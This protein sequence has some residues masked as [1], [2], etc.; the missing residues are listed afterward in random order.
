MR[1]K[2]LL[3]LCFFSLCMFTFGQ[4]FAGGLENLPTS[5][6]IILGAAEQAPYPLGEFWTLQ[7][8]DE[9]GER[10]SFSEDGFFAE[11]DGDLRLES[12]FAEHEIFNLPPGHYYFRLCTGDEFDRQHKPVYCTG[13]WV[14]VEP[15]AEID[16]RDC[17]WQLRDA[18]ER[19]K[20]GNVNSAMGSAM[21]KLIADDDSEVTV[22]LW[23][24]EQWIQSAEIGDDGMFWFEEVESSGG[25]ENQ[26]SFLLEGLYFNSIEVKVP[27]MFWIQ[28]VI[29]IDE[30]ATGNESGVSWQNAMKHPKDA[31]QNWSDYYFKP[32]LRIADGIYIMNLSS[33]FLQDGIQIYGGFDGGEPY[34]WQRDPDQNVVVFTGDLQSDD[35]QTNG[36]TEF[37]GGIR[38]TNA[39]ILFAISS[40][41]RRTILDGF[42]VTGYHNSGGAV[43][44]DQ[45]CEAVLRNIRF[46]GNQGRVGGALNTIPGCRPRIES[47][48]FQGNEA[49]FGGAIFLGDERQ[50]TKYSR[51]TSLRI[52]DC[53]F[54]GNEATEE[55]GG[56]IFFE[57]AAADSNSSIEFFTNITNC[58]F[59][60][61]ESQGNG[62][63]IAFSSSEEGGIRASLVNCMFSGNVSTAGAVLSSSLYHQDGLIDIEIINCSMNHNRANYGETIYNDVGIHTA[64]PTRGSTISIKNSILWSGKVTIPPYGEFYNQGQT[65][66]LNFE[67]NIIYGGVQNTAM[68]VNKYGATHVDQGGNLGH[69]PKFID[70]DGPDGVHGTLDDNLRL[71]ALSPA[72]DSGG[73]IDFSR[74]STATDLDGKPRW[75]NTVDRGAYEK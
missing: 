7:V 35:V 57:S 3:A 30:N 37:V 55:H 73:S 51:T 34:R 23:A 61:N 65:A 69:F 19:F 36:V 33:F 56:A 64:V 28:T 49:E 25:G 70:P 8:F 18:I 2:Q 6:R 67:N 16:L 44:L 21:G 27:D 5:N 11:G 32:E 59:L 75:H 14:E 41:S 26:L 50:N 71:Q 62:G 22:S 13:Q 46:L 31:I 74:Y 12:Q 10:I 43:S 20:I 72:I 63:A 15:E 29:Y 9:S 42:T 52:H 17:A 53:T 54:I 24:N 58:R 39:S 38:G 48:W 60:G 68:I 40:A 4:L 66:K 47:C 45:R 1:R